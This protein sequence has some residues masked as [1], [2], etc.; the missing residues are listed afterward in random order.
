MNAEIQ[1]LADKHGLEN[2][3]VQAAIWV[4]IRGELLGLKQTVGGSI[5]PRL[6]RRYAG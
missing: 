6:Y 4:G 3:Q 1:R 2:E 5:L